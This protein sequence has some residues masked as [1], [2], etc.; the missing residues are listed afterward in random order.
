[1]GVQHD[2]DASAS[3]PSAP[4]A[5]QVMQGTALEPVQQETP[6]VPSPEVPAPASEPT[7]GQVSSSD[8]VISGRFGIVITDIGLAVT[9]EMVEE[10]VE[11]CGEVGQIVMQNDP[12]CEGKQMAIVSFD[13]ADDVDTALLLTGAILGDSTVTISKMK[14]VNT[15][16]DQYDKV[17]AGARSVSERVQAIIKAGYI[18]GEALTST[19]KVKAQEVDEKYNIRERAK[20]GGGGITEKA[21]VLAATASSVGMHLVSNHNVPD[22]KN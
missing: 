8:A 19:L 4:P 13:T 6:E 10:F 3:A 17:V 16:P 12:Q 22:I 11:F 14:I 21:K 20:E 7:S 15:G 18:K 9:R 1:M 2:E 5:E